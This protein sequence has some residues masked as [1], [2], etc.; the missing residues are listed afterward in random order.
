MTDDKDKTFNERRKNPRQKCGKQVGFAIH[1]TNYTAFI[2]DISIDGAFVSSKGPA[3]VGQ[4]VTISLQIDDET[5]PIT[6][7]G[8]IIRVTPEGF[9]V[10]FTMGIDAAAL[11]IITK[12]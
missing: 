5:N 8:E 6:M 9:G 2:H 12:S 3:M 1:D 11:Q 7:I 10:K 4:T